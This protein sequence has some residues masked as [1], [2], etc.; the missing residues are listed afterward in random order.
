MFFEQ[1]KCERFVALRES[2]VADHVREH[3][4]GE[5]AMFGLHLRH[6]AADLAYETTRKEVPGQRFALPSEA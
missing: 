4:R 6:T 5:F 2:A 1:L 3:N